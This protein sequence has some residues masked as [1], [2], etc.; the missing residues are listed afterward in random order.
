MSANPN[1]ANTNAV[2]NTSNNDVPSKFCRRFRTSCLRKKSLRDGSTLRAPE[3]TVAMEQ[4]N[5]KL[6]HIK[7]LVGDCGVESKRTEGK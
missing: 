3:I 6:L 1:A 2:E 4:K 5:D 7:M